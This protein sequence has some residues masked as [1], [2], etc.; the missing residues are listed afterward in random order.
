MSGWVYVHDLDPII[1]SLGPLRVGWYGMMYAISF[2]SGYLLLARAIRKG[3]APIEEKD[4]GTWATYMILGVIVGARLGWVI[5]YGGMPY[6][7]SPW[8]ILETWKGGMSFHGGMLAVALAFLL[9][10]R[11]YRVPILK[12]ADFVLPV[13]PLGLFWGRMGNFING[14]LYGKPTDGS[15]GVIFPSDP[16]QVPRH[17]SQLYEAALEGLVIL[18]VL[19][20]MKGRVRITGMQPAMFLFL[21]G[22]FRIAVEFVRLP[23]R[24]I[25]Y[26]WDIVTRGQMLSLPMALVGGVWIVYLLIGA[27]R[28]TAQS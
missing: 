22:L 6:L 9:F 18:A 20:F 13:V 3:G 5:F 7:V 2:L 26:S 14:E 28:K 4:L 15:W 11:R 19:Q 17:P 10:S 12:L 24:D 23:D 16:T 27:R 1:V 25:G 8:R 21:Y